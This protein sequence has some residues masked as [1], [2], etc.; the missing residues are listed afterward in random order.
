MAEAL[1]SNFELNL[2]A[3]VLAD[4]R[5]L[6]EIIRRQAGL[7]AYWQDLLT[8]YRVYLIAAAE[9][10]NS[11]TSN[12]LARAKLG[13]AAAAPTLPELVTDHHPSV[14]AASFRGASIPLTDDHHTV[15]T[16]GSLSLPEA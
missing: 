5:G 10:G 8:R 15:R 2:V 4:D 13:S 7:R 11:A 1:L 16:E 3:R 9:R 14:R 6:L 12:R